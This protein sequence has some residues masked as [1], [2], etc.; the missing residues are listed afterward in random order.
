MHQIIC[1]AVIGKQSARKIKTK[2]NFKN[3]VRLIQQILSTTSHVKYIKRHSTVHR[4]LNHK[5]VDYHELFRNFNG[6]LLHGKM[7]YLRTKTFNLDG[8]GGLQ[9][10]WHNIRNDPEMVSRRVR[11]EVSVMIWGP[12]H[13]ISRWICAEKM[14]SWINKQY[15][16]ILQH[17]LLSAADD[18]FGENWTFQNDNWP[19]RCSNYT[20]EWFEASDV[21]VLDW[22][23]KAPDLSTIKNFWGQL[24]RSVYTYDK[25]YETTSELDHAVATSW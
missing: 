3:F 11:V 4:T 2:L 7:L 10:Y 8:A 9:H 19:A 16:D 24:G 12:S 15:C 6:T 25:Q 18:I 5:K 1:R 22:P 23:A 20:K 21:D 13:T 14:V 17:Y